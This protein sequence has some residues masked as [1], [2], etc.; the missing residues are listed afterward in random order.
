MS[1]GRPVFDPETDGLIVNRGPMHMLHSRCVSSESGA[2]QVVEV[3]IVSFTKLD[4]AI[5][6][7]CWVTTIGFTGIKPFR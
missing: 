2:H 7:S 1:I 4:A 6:M 3:I 5:L